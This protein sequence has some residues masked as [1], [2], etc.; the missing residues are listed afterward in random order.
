MKGLKREEQTKLNAI[1]KWYRKFDKMVETKKA[2][3][4]GLIQREKDRKLLE[5]KQLFQYQSTQILKEQRNHMRMQQFQKIANEKHVQQVENKKMKLKNS[6]SHKS[7][8]NS[9]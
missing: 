9:I 4:D 7:V 5:Q 2:R 8:H 1:S 6:V 3:V